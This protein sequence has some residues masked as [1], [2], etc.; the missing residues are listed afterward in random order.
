MPLR[1]KGPYRNRTDR[2]VCP[3]DAVQ[4]VSNPVMDFIV[5]GNVGAVVTIVFDQQVIPPDLTDPAVLNSVRAF[6]PDGNFTGTALAG[7]RVD[8]T[9]YSFTF[10]QAPTTGDIYAVWIFDHFN[11]FR[12]ASTGARSTGNPAFGEGI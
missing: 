10:D 5:D 9:T 1:P 8:G 7:V 3:A 2:R 6:M 12:G 4:P 11:F